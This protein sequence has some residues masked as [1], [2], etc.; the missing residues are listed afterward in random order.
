MIIH[1]VHD[2]F[3]REVRFFSLDVAVIEQTPV[4]D[5][6]DQGKV[7]G[8]A[9]K[10]LPQFLRFECYLLDGQHAEL[11]ATPLAQH[12]GLDVPVHDVCVC[13]VVRP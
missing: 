5:D 12:I 7:H 8:I 10:D 3:K 2:V 6:R 4:H 1:E 9:P 11:E 13:L